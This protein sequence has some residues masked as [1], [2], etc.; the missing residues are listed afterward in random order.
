MTASGERPNRGAR[1][2][3][4]FLRNVPVPE[5]MCWASPS[6]YGARDRLVVAGP[7]A[8][9]RN[10]MYVGWAL[11]HLGAAMAGGA[12]WVLASFLPVASWMQ[13]EV[14][15]EEQALADSFSEEFRRFRATEPATRRRTRSGQPGIA[16]TPGRARR[17]MPWPRT[18]WRART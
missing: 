18:W 7:Y 12:G 8:V 3:W 15:R 17:R 1:R 11:L 9:S 2:R 13:W 10:L 5:R 14:L 6:A 4:V 16:V